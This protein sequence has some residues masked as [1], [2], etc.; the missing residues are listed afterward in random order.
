MAAVR[1][2]GADLIEHSGGEPRVAGQEGDDDGFGVFA[3]E[4]EEGGFQE[5]A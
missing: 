1:N 4:A 3:E 5:L 2:E